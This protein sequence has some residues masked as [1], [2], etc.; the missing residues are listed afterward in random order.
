LPEEF[1]NPWMTNLQEVGLPEPIAGWPP[2]PGWYLVLGALLVLLSWA[3]WRIFRRRQAG[4]YR[5][6]ALVC[7]DDLEKRAALVE[8]PA[9]LK[10]T[11]LAAYPRAKVAGITGAE[12]LAFLDE[13][14]GDSSFSAGPGRSLV[15]LAYAPRAAGDGDVAALLALSR[16][17]IRQH[18]C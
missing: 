15:D 2:A 6:E 11:A 18:R 1:G 9:L 8:L 5:R 12:W 10:R 14:L 7:L 16:R 3:L 17:W 4:A 13:T